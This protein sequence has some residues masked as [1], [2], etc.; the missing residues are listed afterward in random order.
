MVASHVAV[1]TD[2]AHA[3]MLVAD[4]AH[5][6]ATTA[7]HAVHEAAATAVHAAAQ[8]WV[9]WDGELLRSL[10]GGVMAAV[11]WAAQAAPMLLVLHSAGCVAS[12]ALPHSNAHGGEEGAEGVTSTSEAGPE[13]PVVAALRRVLLP[14]SGSELLTLLA[15]AAA[16]WGLAPA[17]VSA[18]GA[19]MTGAANLLGAATHTFHLGQAWAQVTAAAVTAM[20]HIG[21]SPA[22]TGTAGSAV[23]PALVQSQLQLAGAAEWASRMMAWPMPP[24]LQALAGHEGVAGA[25]IRAAAAASSS[26]ILPSPTVLLALHM[27]HTFGFLQD[28]AA[29]WLPLARDVQEAGALLVRLCVLAAGVRVALLLASQVA[30]TA[31]M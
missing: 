19:A 28:P 25:V 31:A 21:I 24:S 2:A 23:G 27:A 13:G 30:V 20:Q 29:N 3:A 1:P 10:G 6:A 8:E 5:E 16:C 22:A 18:C 15:V 11:A 9:P 12:A 4:M 14:S 26:F 7:A 17:L